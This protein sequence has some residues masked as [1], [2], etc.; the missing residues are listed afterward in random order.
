MN[1]TVLSRKCLSDKEAAP[2]R[3]Y[4]CKTRNIRKRLQKLVTCAAASCTYALAFLS[5]RNGI[6][7]TLRSGNDD[8]AGS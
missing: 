4:A 5:E 7:S 6:S 3:Q 2:A 8:T 1:P